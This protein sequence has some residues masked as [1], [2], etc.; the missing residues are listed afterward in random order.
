MFL[1]LLF[2]S[3]AQLQ[4][5]LAAK[6]SNSSEKKTPAPAPQVGWKEVRHKGRGYVSLEEV[7]QFYG[8]KFSRDEKWTRLTDDKVRLEFITGTKGLLLNGLQFYLSYAVLPWGEDRVILSNFDLVNVIDPTLRPSSQRDP[9]QLQ[10][11][12]ID[13]AHGG[14]AAG[15]NGRC[16][17]EKNITLDL[18]LRV[19][20]HLAGAPFRVVLTREGDFDLTVAERLT[21]A[22]ATPGESVFVSLHLGNGNTK[23]RGLEIFTLPPPY[24]PATYDPPSTKPDDSFYPGNINDRESLALAV[25]IQGQALRKKLRTLGLKRARFDELK[26]ISVPAVY[27]RA[28]FVS[29]KEDAA[30]LGDPDH[31]DKTAKVIAAGIRRYARVI[32]GGMEEH[33]L[34]RA[35]NPL[36]ISDVEV[37]SD[38]VRSLE[39]EKRRVRLDI[40]AKESISVDPEKLE[41]QVFFFDHVNQ[42]SLDLSTADPPE[43]QWISVLPDWKA[44]DTEVMEVGYTLPAMSAEEQKAFGQR[45]Y[46]GFVARLVYDGRLVDSYAEP[47]NLRRG[48]PH[49]ITVFP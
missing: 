33:Q 42:E 31:I 47:A 2:L 3:M 14:R 1:G 48:L 8:L 29:N 13:P 46:Y 20:M 10:T 39:G 17:V 9:S 19:K 6:E 43:V 38:Q 37:F 15:V 25:A 16:G 30:L 4:L 12:I 5:E 21:L 41:V 44:T 27:C 23:A 40:Q 49:F 24:T 11:V 34:Q 7:A 26:G 35:K 22:G 45:F 28:G 32:E 36:I 18:A